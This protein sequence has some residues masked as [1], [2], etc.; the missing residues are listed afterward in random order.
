MAS[1]SNRTSRLRALAWVITRVLM[2]LLGLWLYHSGR[3]VPGLLLGVL[4]G[5]TTVARLLA[6]LMRSDTHQR[7]V[8]SWGISA[9]D[10][11]AMRARAIRL[12]G[13]GHGPEADALRR[14][15]ELADQDRS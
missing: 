14:R 9:G 8:E 7:I 6:G 3:R 12:D 15:A 5:V 2:L 13:A 11:S 4:V 10:S 1:D